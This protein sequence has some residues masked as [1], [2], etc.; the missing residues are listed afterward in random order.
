MTSTIITSVSGST[1][2]AKHVCHTG[3]YIHRISSVVEGKTDQEVV[4]AIQRSL[5]APVPVMTL[6]SFR[7]IYGVL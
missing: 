7:R 6:D 4:A 5:R 3:A 1:H 2:I